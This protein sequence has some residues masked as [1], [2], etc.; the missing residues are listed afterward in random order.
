MADDPFAMISKFNATNAAAPQ[1]PAIDLGFGGGDAAAAAPASVGG[2]AGMLVDFGVVG[3][4]PRRVC[5]G[6][7]KNVFDAR[8]SWTNRGMSKHEPPMNT[9]EPK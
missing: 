7:T 5:R 8:R 9:S 1:Q 4:G 6:V 3:P 2:G